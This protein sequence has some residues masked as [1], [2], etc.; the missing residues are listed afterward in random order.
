LDNQ[1]SL[2]EKRMEEGSRL[3]FCWENTELDLLIAIEALIPYSF[4]EDQD[5]V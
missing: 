1:L 5:H 2:D 3:L 4:L